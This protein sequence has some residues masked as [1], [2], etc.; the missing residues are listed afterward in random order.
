MHTCIYISPQ[1][2]HARL[3]NGAA[4]SL[5]WKLLRTYLES[6]ANIVQAVV[7]AHPPAPSSSRR[8]SCW[9]VARHVRLRNPI[10]ST[11]AHDAVADVVL[12]K[13][14]L[15][16]RVGAGLIQFVYEQIELQAKLLNYFLGSNKSNINQLM[17]HT[18]AWP[19]IS[20]S[21]KIYF[22]SHFRG[23]FKYMVSRCSRGR[24]RCRDE[25][26]NLS[27]TNMHSKRT[28]IIY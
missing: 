27:I 15:I 1:L 16:I 26:S 8:S 6:C 3:C 18:R 4:A 12:H 20:P 2:V 25:E 21:T 9:P 17:V 13:H 5:P 28:P 24:S 7:C 11:L 19:R 22:C 10:K 23:L 14:H